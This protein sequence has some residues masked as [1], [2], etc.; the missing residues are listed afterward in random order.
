MF[1]ITLVLIFFCI[2]RKKGNLFRLCF[3]DFFLLGCHFYRSQSAL[4]RPLK[5]FWQFYLLWMNLFYFNLRLRDGKI[6]SAA[7]RFPFLKDFPCIL[8]LSVIDVIKLA[9]CAATHTHT[10]SNSIIKRNRCI[11]TWAMEGRYPNKILVIFIRHVQCGRQA[12]GSDIEILRK[13]CCRGFFIVFFS[14]L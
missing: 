2:F 4:K 12:H 6:N 7:E 8:L 5:M 3:K 9:T 1:I 13:K 14:G 10:W 11:Q